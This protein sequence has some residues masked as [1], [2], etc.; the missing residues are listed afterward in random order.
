MRLLHCQTAR[1][2]GSG[3]NMVAVLVLVRCSR[4]GVV[5]RQL[6]ASAGDKIRW[7]VCKDCIGNDV[8]PEQTSGHE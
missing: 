4:C 2:H 3:D 1:L 7:E 5:L 6:L 8:A